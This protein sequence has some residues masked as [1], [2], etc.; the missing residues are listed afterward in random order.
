[1]VN[2]LFIRKQKTAKHKNSKKNKKFQFDFV[3]SLKSENDT[4]EAEHERT[5]GRYSFLILDD[6][7]TVMRIYKCVANN[8]VGIGSVCEIEVQGKHIL[9]F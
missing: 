6:E 1:M 9:I 4:I 3:W 2:I 7:F 8:S 5:D